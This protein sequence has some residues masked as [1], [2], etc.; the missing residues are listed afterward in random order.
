MSN[1]ELSNPVVVVPRGEYGII[2]TEIDGC[3]HKIAMIG[4]GS[5]VGVLCVK[6]SVAG[7]LNVS[8]KQVINSMF[9]SKIYSML[10]RIKILTKHHIDESMNVYFIGNQDNEDNEDNQHVKN[11][12]TEII[13]NNFYGLLSD[14]KSD[15]FY[16]ENMFDFDNTDGDIFSCCRFDDNLFPRVFEIS[17]L[18]YEVNDIWCYDPIFPDKKY[19]I[20]LNNKELYIS[21]H[22]TLFPSLFC[23]QKPISNFIHHQFQYE[24]GLNVDNTPFEP[25]RLSYDR[26]LKYVKLQ[27]NENMFDV[28]EIDS[29][30]FNTIAFEKKMKKLDKYAKLNHQSKINRCGKI[31]FRTQNTMKHTKCHTINQPIRQFAKQ[32]IRQRK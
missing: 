12:I 31:T 22:T 30:M 10:G 23:S 6:G 14:I 2:S 8:N 5:W 18:S 32:A 19:V 9:R 13:K 29:N 20:D 1:S 7:I 3:P 17:L 24:M 4:R 21:E 25:S 28:I 27:T 11:E 26:A 16:D 15:E